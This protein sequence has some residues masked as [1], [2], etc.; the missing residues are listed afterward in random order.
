MGGEAAVFLPFVFFGVGQG[1]PTPLPG[2]DAGQVGINAFMEL[3]RVFIFD[4]FFGIS[5]LAFLALTTEII[6]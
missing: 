1:S 3:C 2:M 5:R 4:L 6:F